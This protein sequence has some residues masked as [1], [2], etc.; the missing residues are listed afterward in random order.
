M[1]STEV[2]PQSL[3]QIDSQ[4]VSEYVMDLNLLQV[5][6]KERIESMGN[7]RRIEKRWSWAMWVI[8]DQDP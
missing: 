1:A 6:E 2:G 4:R 3:L 8:G 7:S 5:M